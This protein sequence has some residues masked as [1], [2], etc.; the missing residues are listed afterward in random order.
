MKYTTGIKAPEPDPI[1][2]STGLL[3]H[4]MVS[5][6]E[7]HGFDPVCQGTHPL[8]TCPNPDQ[9]T[10]LLESCPLSLACP[11]C[12]SV[13][14]RECAKNP[15]GEFYKE[16]QRKLIEKGN[17]GSYMEYRMLHRYGK[18]W[19][20]SINA[21]TTEFRRLV[22]GLETREREKLEE[23][24]MNKQKS[25]SVVASTSTSSESGLQVV[26]MVKMETDSLNVDV[27][28]DEQKKNTE[29]T[30]K[31]NYEKFLDRLPRKHRCD[32][33]VMEVARHRKYLMSS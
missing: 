1:S 31:S 5:E 6:S 25:V 24:E 12:W 13:Q 3:H 18:I 22:K 26:Q 23:R 4:G 8:S 2:F 19:K 15:Y 33:R 11:S 28:V 10:S 32:I 9:H 30:A 29:K 17:S 7:A 21:G 20:K 14:R 27:C 16:L